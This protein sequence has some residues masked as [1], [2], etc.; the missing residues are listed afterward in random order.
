MS[1]TVKY[2]STARGDA[3][4]YSDRDILVVG[5]IP[6][7]LRADNL[8][9]VRYTKNRLKRLRE[10]ESLFLVHLR[11]EGVI[12]KDHKHWMNDFLIS[13]PDYVPN[14]KVL[15]LAFQNLS[16]AVSLVPSGTALPCWF[17][18]IFVFLR[19]LLVKLNAVNKNYVFAPDRLLE[20][21]EIEQKEKI[22]HII[23]ISR[24]IKSNYRK[25][26]K[27]KI[28][29]DPLWVSK[30]LTSSFELDTSCPDHKGILK[31]SRAFDPYLILRLVEYGILTGDIC[32]GNAQLMKCIK[33]PSRYAWNIRNKQ[34]INTIKFVE[35]NH[36]PDQLQPAASAGR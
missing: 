30:L 36:S 11:K 28:F 35:Q 18:I 13:I 6:N 27:Q 16:V 12:I 10:I 21:L 4:F 22:Q 23:K 20:F 8:D 32:S 15:K 1:I 17:D 34:W 19:D 3:D 31:N 2:G 26:A 29:L 33:N 24:E 9:I 14:P 25:N 7:E 5:D